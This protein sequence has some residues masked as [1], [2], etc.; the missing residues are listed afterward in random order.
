L[1]HFVDLYGLER[2]SCNDCTCAIRRPEFEE[3]V[4]DDE[5]TIRPSQI[6]R[7]QNRPF[8]SVVDPPLDPPNPDS[9]DNPALNPRDWQMVKNFQDELDRDILESCSRCNERWFNMSILRELAH[10]LLYSRSKFE[11]LL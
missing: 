1:R 11:S 8:L 9:L 6:W 4:D 5:D 10:A 2:T 7:D 3:D